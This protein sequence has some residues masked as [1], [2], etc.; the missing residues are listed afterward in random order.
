[1]K[2]ISTIIETIW[3]YLLH[4]FFNAVYKLFIIFLILILFLW[5]LTLSYFGNFYFDST[6]PQMFLKCNQITKNVYSIICPGSHSKS[7]VFWLLIVTSISTKCFA[8]SKYIK[9]YFRKYLL[10]NSYCVFIPIGVE[11]EECKVLLSHAKVSFKNR[12]HK[13]AIISYK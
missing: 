4:D 10:S 5:S 1:M 6:V 13:F 2:N 12:D 3:S 9:S 7:M 11:T 8:L